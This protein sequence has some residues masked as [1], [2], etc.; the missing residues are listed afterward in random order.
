MTPRREFQSR[1]GYFSFTSEKNEGP[2]PG[3]FS[4]TTGG[5]LLLPD[6]GLC[7]SLFIPRCSGH[8]ITQPTCFLVNLLLIIDLLK[9]TNPE[10]N[11]GKKNPDYSAL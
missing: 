6:L 8:T 2:F 1:G 11:L 5:T 3:I 4:S 10:I 7:A 9:R